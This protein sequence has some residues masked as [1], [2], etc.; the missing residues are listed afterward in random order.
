MRRM[1]AL[2]A[3]FRAL[4]VSISRMSSL[5]LF[6]CPSR[7]RRKH[8]GRPRMPNASMPDSGLAT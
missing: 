2:S 6:M 1:A 4:S 7:L 8:A 5:R 3:E